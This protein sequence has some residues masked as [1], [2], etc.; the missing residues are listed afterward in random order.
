MIIEK[1]EE[2]FPFICPDC[3]GMYD[4]DVSING[5]CV[6]SAC[7]SDEYNLYHKHNCS[8]EVDTNSNL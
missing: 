1:N 3:K 6:C 7:Q 8:V 4:C 2:S 5:F